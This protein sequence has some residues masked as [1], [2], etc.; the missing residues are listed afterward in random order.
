M[1]NRTQPI[2]GIIGSNNAKPRLSPSA[3][4][5]SCWAAKA[6]SDEARVAKIAPATAV[7]ERLGGKLGFE[8][9]SPFGMGRREGDF[10][11]GFVDLG[12]LR[13]HLGLRIA[14]EVTVEAIDD[15][16]VLLLEIKALWRRN[17]AF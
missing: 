1:L 4:S 2:A 5:A 7:L 10:G 11:V 14:I 12:D 8:R 6:A 15:A 16:L 17:G 3:M 13:M 9:D